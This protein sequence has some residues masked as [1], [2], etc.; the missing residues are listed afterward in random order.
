ML[1]PER[2]ALPKIEKELAPDLEASMRTGTSMNR[3]THPR[4][5]TGR[6]WSVNKRCVTVE[7]EAR[8]DQKRGRRRGR[9]TVNKRRV[10]VSRTVNKR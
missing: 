9:K 6:S 4:S 5:G 2:E 8:R 7:E 1:Q 10:T 3:F